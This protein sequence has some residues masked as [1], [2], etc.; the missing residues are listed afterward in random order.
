MTLDDPVS[1]P[2][3]PTPKIRLPTPTDRIV[4]GR[5]GV[6]VSPICVGMTNDADTYCEAFDAGCN[7][8][9]LT[10]DMHWPLYAT[11]RDALA[12]L[13]Q[14]GHGIRDE[15]VVA[16]ACYP[17]QP[18]FCSMPFTELVDA[19]RGL[20]HVDV[21]VAGGAYASDWE[22]RRE[23]YGRHRELGHAGARAVGATFHE[24]AAVAPAV[25]GQE[26]DIAFLRYN[27]LHLG[28]RR[29]VFPQL[30]PGDRS[31]LFNF[32]SSIG[33]RPPHR[34]E[35]AGY[36]DLWL[37]DVTDHYRFA[38]TPPAMD[39]L[40]C[41]LGEPAHVGA[42]VDALAEGPLDEADQTHLIALSRLVID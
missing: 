34:Y 22:V 3:A 5:S 21:A 11:A 27:P 2:E 4:L 25:R 31:P 16:G 19:V 12:R 36:D 8:F 10:C 42:L 24:R 39:G 7:F 1:T 26:V 33:W 17:T 29:E 15:I 18:E 13:L 14:R 6:E 32:K 37:P 35:V 40:L 30:P 9:F 41:M 20:G 23:V 38:L 28:A